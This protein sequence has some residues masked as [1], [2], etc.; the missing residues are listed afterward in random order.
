MSNTSDRSLPS[1]AI[2]SPCYN[3]EEALPETAKVLDDLLLELINNKLIS[4]ASKAYYVDDGSSD[5]TWDMIESLAKNSNRVVGVKLTANK[6][7][8]NAL[9]AGLCSTNEDAVVSIDAD[10]QDDPSHIKSMLEEF[11]KGSDVVY[12]V[13]CSRETDSAF[14][15]ITAQKY[16]KFMQLLGVD[17]IYNH[18]DFRLT[19]RAA[20]NALKEYSEANLFLRG[21]VRSVGFK[22]SIVEYE[23]QERNAGESKYPLRKMLSFA[24]EGIASFSTAPLR[25]ITIMGFLSG[26]LS[27]VTL[28]W[29]LSIRIFTEKAIP[30]WAS[31]L[32]PLLFIGSVQ[33][34]CLGV[35]GE[36]VAKIYSEVK[37]R[38]RYHIEKIHSS[39]EE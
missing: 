35:I 5:N 3:E 32:L 30:G 38:P 14:K 7:H 19:S 34:M 25:A 36:Y 9:L 21:I 31:I 1:L 6:G 27:L 10:L 17:L 20:L 11:K 13:R 15:R 26:W 33:L 8:Q 16:Y 39:D 2:V 4:P 23:R 22:S 24:W 12:G 29:V 37:R 18:A 28:F